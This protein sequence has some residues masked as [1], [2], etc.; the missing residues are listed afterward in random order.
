MLLRR[1]FYYYAVCVARIRRLRRGVSRERFRGPKMHAHRREALALRDLRP[2]RKDNPGLAP[3][4]GVRDS[5]A[6]VSRSAAERPARGAV[7][8]CPNASAG[9]V[10]GPSVVHDAQRGAS[11]RVVERARADPAPG[12]RRRRVPG[13]CRAPGFGFFGLGL[14]VY[15]GASA[16]DDRR[17]VRA[18][19]A[20][21]GDLRRRRRPSIGVAGDLVLQTPSATPSGPFERAETGEI[22][23]RRRVG[24]GYRGDHEG[25]GGALRAGARHASR[26]AVLR[27]HRHD[28]ELRVRQRQPGASVVGLVGH[29]DPE[30]GHARDTEGLACD[31][32]SSHAG[33]EARRAQQN[34]SLVPERLVNVM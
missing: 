12:R 9:N 21:C 26:G 34:E 31:P 25:R 27:R 13:V 16:R 15:S 18:I 1:S 32:P 2:Q 8:S 30:G 22:R 5:G 11:V 29:A 33:L 10:P 19:G 3:R 24:G 28:R 17:S 20:P 6:G 4:T 23:R 14:S 7:S